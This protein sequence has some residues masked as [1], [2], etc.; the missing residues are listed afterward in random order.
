MDCVVSQNMVPHISRAQIKQM[1]I[2]ANQTSINFDNFFT[3]ALPD[4]VVNLVGLVSDA[5]LAV[6]Y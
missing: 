3:G 2:H 5:D 4:L 1:S 6:G